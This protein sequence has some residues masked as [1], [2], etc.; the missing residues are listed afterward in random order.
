MFYPI[1]NILP[2]F[3]QLKEVCT[4]KNAPEE[5]INKEFPWD[6]F[7]GASQ[8]SP[9]KEGVGGILYL[10]STQNISFKVKLGTETNKFYE[11]MKTKLVLMLALENK[12]SQI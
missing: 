12:I 6:F 11:L 2:T 5:A 10:S 8:G 3:S 9:P 4:T 1:L 7:D